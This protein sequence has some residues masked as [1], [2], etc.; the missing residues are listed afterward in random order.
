MFHLQEQLLKAHQDG[1]A[2]LLAFQ[3]PGLPFFGKIL[4]WSST[5]LPEKRYMGYNGYIL[6]S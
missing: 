1:M 6:Q 2:P 5:C 3:S 4:P